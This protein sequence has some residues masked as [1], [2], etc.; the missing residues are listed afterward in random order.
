MASITLQDM[1]QD[2]LETV[3]GNFVASDGTLSD[4]FL[5]YIS[6]YLM[7]DA[8]ITD[9]I[10]GFWEAKTPNKNFEISGCAWDEDR[11]LLTLIGCDF[12]NTDE[13]QTVTKEIYE[14][15]FKALRNFLELATDPEKPLFVEMEAT[16]PA[17]LVAKEIFDNFPRARTVEFMLLTNGLITRTL[18]KKDAKITLKG[19]DEERYSFKIFDINRIFQIKTSETSFEDLEVD[20][21]ETTKDHKGLKCLPAI[22]EGCADYMSY[23]AIMPAE[24]LAKI[25]EE[26]GQKLLEQNVRTFLQLKKKIN[27]G[28]L[29][30]IEEAPERFFAYNNGLTCTASEPKFKREGDDLYLQSARGFQIVNGGQTTNVIHT[31]W[32]SK[33]D[34]TNVSV[35]M[36]LSVVEDGDKYSDF[37]E[38]VARFANTQNPVKESDFFSNSEF[39]KKFKEMSQ[40]IWTPSVDGKQNKTRWYYERTRGQYE[41]D[42]GKTQ[43]EKNEFQRFNPKEQKIDKIILAKTE[44]IFQGAPYIANK[45]QLAF[46]YFADNVEKKIEQDDSSINDNYFHELIAKVILAKKTDE[47]IA[48]TDWYKENRSVKSEYKAYALGLLNKYVLSK[49]RFLDFEFVWTRQ[50]IH[51]PFEKAID[52]SIKAVRRF[53]LDHYPNPADWREK[54]KM[55]GLWENDISKI[56]LDLPADVLDEISVSE[57]TQKTDKKA[58]RKEAKMVNGM[59]ATVFV[60][61]IPHEHWRLLLTFYT[62]HRELLS[63]EKGI[64]EYGVLTSMANGRIAV[65]SDKQARIL[66]KLYCLAQEHDV[67]FS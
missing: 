52:I 44:A 61:N 66:Q 19:M 3:R 15:K 38:K 25:Y 18:N 34:L 5:E 40:R 43:S 56:D 67:K 47:M 46:A 11:K 57:E 39:H 2:V 64:T 21:C 51:K 16:D 36:K 62:K 4:K 60:V 30:T 48:D 35:Q 63:D 26:F 65:P 37:V 50:G 29:I 32:E 49:G 17:A 31:A 12:F 58:A 45:Q 6:I 1:Y 14:R 7:Q 41:V 8:D 9:P 24:T 20:F 33:K 23:L 54:F 22:C 53:M 10:L 28:M 27:K 59:E 42:C 55:K 13:I